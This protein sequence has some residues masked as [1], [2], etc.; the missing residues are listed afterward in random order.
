MSH[1]DAIKEAAIE[2]AGGF[3]DLLSRPAQHAQ[4]GWIAAIGELL[5]LRDDACT[6]IVSLNDRPG[7]SLD[8]GTVVDLAREDIGE[9][10]LLL[11]EGEGHRAVIVGVLHRDRSAV[12]K[13]LAGDVDLSADGERMVVTA[14]RELVLRCGKSSITLR[15]DGTVE[16]RGERIV[17]RAT[18]PNRV[19]G[20]SVHLN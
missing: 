5:A 10:V 6:A 16:I 14:R 7:V 11:R 4:A 8:A 3:D 18:G 2:P 12:P 13:P 1:H 9:Q 19:Q 17:S 20:G 15:H